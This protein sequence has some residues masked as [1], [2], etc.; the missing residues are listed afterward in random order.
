MPRIL[1]TRDAGRLF[2]IRLQMHRQLLSLRDSD[3]YAYLQR[4]STAPIIE[5]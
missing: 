2:A 5:K 1:P 4:G 3:H